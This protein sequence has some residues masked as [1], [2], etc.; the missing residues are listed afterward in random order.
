MNDRWTMEG[1]HRVSNARTYVCPQ[2]VSLISMKFGM[3]HD[4]RW[5]AVWPDSRSRLRALES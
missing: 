2:N 4:A 1:F 3:Y 5:Y